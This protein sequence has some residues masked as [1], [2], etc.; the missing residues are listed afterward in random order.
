[1]KQLTSPNVIK[2]L[3]NQYG[4]RFSKS[5]GQNFLIDEA[6]LETITG[7]AFLNGDDLVLEIGP[8]FGTLTQRLCQTAKKVVAVEIDRA[9]IPVLADTLCGFDNLT[10]LNEDILKVDL[11]SLINEQ[12][13]GNPFK[14]AA[15]L[16]YYITTPIIMAV[17]R[18]GVPFTHMVAMVQ[19]E[20]AQRFCAPPG[21]KDYGAVT[22]AVDYYC[23]AERILDVPP[24]SFLPPPK[25]TSSVIR[26][27]RRKAPKVQVKD[28]AVFFKT[29]KAAFAQRRKT[30]LNTLANAGGFGHPKAR[31]S[32][33][34]T[35]CGIDPARRGETLS[36]EEFAA[37][38]DALIEN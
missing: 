14:V 15:N 2:D 20:V 8:G 32:E 7:A 25:V 33:I 35:A 16:P 24:S 9:V 1:M 12:F 29:V 5:L 23:E 3:L 31:L 11:P 21:G 22:V 19:K 28:E 17:L 30:L 4:F 13:L 18:S 27:T 36:I 6:A 10:V 26:L 38:S 37:L 34:L